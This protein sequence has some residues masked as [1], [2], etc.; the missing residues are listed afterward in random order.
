MRANIKEAL[1]SMLGNS[2]HTVIKAAATCVAA[3]AVIE[4]PQGEWNEV[5]QI[6]SDNANSQEINV[7]LASV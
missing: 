5:I 2:D 1:L 6:L 3:I 4:V 7:R